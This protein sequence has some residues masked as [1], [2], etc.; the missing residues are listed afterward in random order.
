M[1]LSGE[2]GASCGPILGD[3]GAE[4]AAGVVFAEVI[5]GRSPREVGP[6]GL[7]RWGCMGRREVL[8]RIEQKPILEKEDLPWGSR[9]LRGRRGRRHV[10]WSLSDLNMRSLVCSMARRGPSR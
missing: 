3:P 10:G 5:R 2:G 9:S 6:F 4:G 1:P 8:V 7:V